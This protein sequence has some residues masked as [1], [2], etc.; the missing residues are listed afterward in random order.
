MLL[1]APVI[2][3]SEKTAGEDGTAEDVKDAKGVE[4]SKESGTEAKASKESGAEAKASEESG[5]EAKASEEPGTEA[6]AS[7]PAATDA[8]AASTPGP[9]KKAAAKGGDA[10][11]EPGSGGPTDWPAG[12]P[13]GPG[14]QGWPDGKTA[15]D[16]DNPDQEATGPDGG[17]PDDG[18]G[19]ACTD[20]IDCVC[21]M[22]ELAGGKTLGGYNHEGTCMVAKTYTTSEYEVLCAE[23]L[24]QVKDALEDA[25]EDY[26][27]NGIK[28]P[29][30]CQ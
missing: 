6:K 21:G 2:A 5:A 27:A 16:F 9:A 30:A 25:K 11:S 17:S 19:V 22:S 10:Y 4:A 8:A 12:K 7:E 18:I 13:P 26:K 15:K 14:P 29:A 20:Y 24:D 1:A 28:L 23:E 3:E